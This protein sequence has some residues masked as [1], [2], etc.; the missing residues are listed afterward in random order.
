MSNLPT[1]ANDRLVTLDEKAQA[2]INDSMLKD[3]GFPTI[4][5]V[6]LKAG[7]VKLV[8]QEKDRLC[9][10]QRLGLQEMIRERYG[11]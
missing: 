6:A 2:V 4:D 5:R 7:I 1:P 3:A 9:A 10:E 11:K 8:N